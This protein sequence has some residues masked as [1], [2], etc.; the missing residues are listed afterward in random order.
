[1]DAGT[2]KPA[3][4]T[5]NCFPV[6][7]TLDMNMCVEYHESEY[8]FAFKYAPTGTDG[9]SILN[10]KIDLNSFKQRADT[11]QD[12][13]YNYAKDIARSYLEGNPNLGMERTSKA[14]L[15]Y[16]EDYSCASQSLIYDMNTYAYSQ[17]SY[18]INSVSYENQNGK[19]IAK[20]NLTVNLTTKQKSSS[21]YSYNSV[22]IFEDGK[23]KEY[24]DQKP[25]PSIS[26]SLVTCEDW[27]NYGK[28]VGIKKVFT[29][30]D[31]YVNVY[32]K[33][34]NIHIGSVV[35]TKWYRPDGTLY[36]ESEHH[37]WNFAYPKCAPTIATDVTGYYIKGH[38]SSW[39]KDTYRIE[40]YVD[41]VKV[42]ET[43]FEYKP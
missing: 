25:S 43:T 5:G 4:D 26:A 3:T 11:N 16:G 38:T 20:I 35:Y 27:D 10:W 13:V 7:D 24:G 15:S 41:N 21:S 19:Q 1:M 32:V 23:W 22:L 31:A 30:A 29:S 36:G 2:L 33:A 6:S 18:L 14:Y 42:G 28:P 39:T 12:T 8:G 9:D 34:D 37:T 17:Y 40:A